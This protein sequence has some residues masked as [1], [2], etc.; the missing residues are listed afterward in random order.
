MVAQVLRFVGARALEKRLL[1]KQA[2]G[3]ARYGRLGLPIGGLPMAAY[4]AWTNRERIA[5]AYRW[6]RDQVTHRSSTPVSAGV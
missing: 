1:G 3:W 5:S 2:T 4:L 6:A